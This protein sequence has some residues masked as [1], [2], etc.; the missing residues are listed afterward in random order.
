MT[1]IFFLVLEH[2]DLIDE[3]LQWQDNS[4]IFQGLKNPSNNY[5]GKCYI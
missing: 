4:L 3:L 1:D 2:S 5:Y